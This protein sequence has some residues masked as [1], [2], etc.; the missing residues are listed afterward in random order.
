M[1]KKKTTNSTNLMSYDFLPNMGGNVGGGLYSQLAQLGR[2]QRSQP[3]MNQMATQAFFSPITTYINKAEEQAVAGMVEYN[4]ANPDVDDSQLFDGT[5]EAIGS[6]LQENSARFRE[7]NRKLAY[8]SPNNKDYADTVTE[9]NKINKAN[10]DLRDQN[11][12]LLDIRNL[13][14]SSD[15]SEFSFSNGAAYR[16]MYTDIQQG[17][18][19]NFSIKNGKITWT[20]PKAGN[21]KSID[22]DTI[23][24]E[25][26]EFVNKAGY[27]FHLQNKLDTYKIN[28]KGAMTPDALNVMAYKMREELGE[29]GLKSLIWD[30]QNGTN[31]LS[32]NGRFYNTEPFIQQ[33]IASAGKSVSDPFIV[34]ELKTRNTNYVLPGANKSIG[35]AFMDYYKTELA[36]ETTFGQGYVPPKPEEEESTSTKT[37]K[38][39]GFLYGRNETSGDPNHPDPNKRAGYQ[40]I[41][42]LKQMQN[43]SALLNFNPEDPQ[44]IRGLHYDYNY[45]KDEGWQAFNNGDFVKNVK[46]SQIANIEGLLSANDVRA[47]EGTSMFNVSNVLKD[48]KTKAEE[49]RV[50]PTVPGTVGLRDIEAKGK[51][52]NAQY[53][54]VRDNLFNVFNAQFREDF[55][56]LPITTTTGFGGGMFGTGS[57]TSTVRNK[58]R[59][60]SKDGSFDE[61]YNIGEN[62]TRDIADQITQDFSAYIVPIDPDLIIK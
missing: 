7:L 20:N 57:T 27:E 41:G 17:N 16:D 19:D 45:D 5:E 36:K 46:G 28:A 8:M 51:T 49:E 34:D 47:G 2:V 4:M 38:Y 53:Q 54:E 44:T 10:V 60:K 37:D 48:Q 62:A 40:N 39:G 52:A 25:G 3:V 22:V 58:I 14:K 42:Y 43:R 33:Y 6:E 18:K 13:I 35:E 21:V 11:K 55:D 32:K 30:N 9:I 26:P 24:A 31:A 56:I 15:M 12:K 50:A 29:S 59:I 1:A 61:T 23:P